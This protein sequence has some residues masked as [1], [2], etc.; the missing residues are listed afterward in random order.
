MYMCVCKVDIKKPKIAFRHP[1]NPSRLI[2]PNTCNN[3]TCIRRLQFYLVFY[4]ITGA[5]LGKI[6]R[7]TRKVIQ[8]SHVRSNV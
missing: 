6:G 5:K 2:N 8:E 3:T 7:K 1:E 4:G